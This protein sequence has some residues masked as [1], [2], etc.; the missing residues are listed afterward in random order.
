[1]NI[2]SNNISYNANF[3][4]SERLEYNRIS[5]NIVTLSNLMNTYADPPPWINEKYELYCS[6]LEM[7]HTHKTKTVL[8]KIRI[9]HKMEGEQPTKYFANLAKKCSP[10][11]CMSKIYKVCKG[12]DPI[13]LEN[14]D[15]IQEEFT[16]Y[17]Y[18]LFKERETYST[19][20]N[21]YKCVSKN[22][23]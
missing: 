11:V 23:I 17:Y 12:K 19:H 20:S 13:L 5:N 8:Q 14:Q 15:E 22:K 3:K 9:K 7:L 1:M 18:E 2:R 10:K 4:K 16:N 21:I 6:Q